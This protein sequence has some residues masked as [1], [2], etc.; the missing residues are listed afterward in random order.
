[1]IGLVIKNLR[2]RNLNI[3]LVFTIIFLFG[4]NMSSILD[5]TNNM[6]MYFPLY[7]LISIPEI[8][9]YG[10]EEGMKEIKFVQ[11]RRKVKKFF[12]WLGMKVVFFTM[13]MTCVAFAFLSFSDTSFRQGVGYETYLIHVLSAS[14]LVGA[15]GLLSAV[16]FRNRGAV[17]AVGFLFWIYW[18]IHFDHLSPLNP[19]LF[20]ANPIDCL[21]WIPLQWG[22][23]VLL[24]SLTCWLNT[25]TPYFLKEL[26]DHTKQVLT[27][28]FLNGALRKR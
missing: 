22:L 21:E 14:M 8:V 7:A 1:M 3:A 15:I 12:I 4:F 6:V 10:D 20:I 11:E 2:L 25:K 17:Y 24:L 5:F 27:E 16:I 19:F 28:Q 18:N 26:V 23:I 13:L 9:L